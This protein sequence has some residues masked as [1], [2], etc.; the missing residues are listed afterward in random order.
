M[1][2]KPLKLIILIFSI[3]I[4]LLLFLDL[5]KLLDVS[6]LQRKIIYVMLFV[7]IIYNLINSIKK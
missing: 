4:F 5:F 6:E 1:S 3:I 7:I 2:I